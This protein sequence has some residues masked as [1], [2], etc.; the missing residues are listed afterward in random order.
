[1]NNGVV[2]LRLAFLLLLVGSSVVAGC[3]PLVPPSPSPTRAGTL[4]PSG[5]PPSGAIVHPTAPSATP[6]STPAPT[7][8]PTPSA[9]PTPPLDLVGTCYLYFPPKTKYD[10]LDYP[11]RGNLYRIDPNTGQINLLLTGDV[12]DFT[13]SPD[14]DQIAYILHGAGNNQILLRSLVDGKDKVLFEGSKRILQP[15]WSPD[16]REIA[17]IQYTNELDWWRTGEIWIVGIY[18]P[19]IRRIADGFDP[20]W[21]PD[22]QNLAYATRPREGPCEH[23]GLAV[24]D[25][26]GKRSRVVFDTDPQTWTAGQHINSDPRYGNQLLVYSPSWSPDGRYLLFS[27]SAKHDGLYRIQ[28]DSGEMLELKFARMSI[29]GQFVRG[30]ERVVALASEGQGWITLYLLAVTSVG[31]VDRRQLNQDGDVVI[32]FALSPDRRRVAFVSTDYLGWSRITFSVY[33]LQAGEEVL[34]QELFGD[35]GKPHLAARGLEWAPR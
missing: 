21:M 11:Y 19:S 27:V 16:G 28:L 10:A 5:S 17:F 4:T 35:I 12:Q 34:R 24:V 2:L 18:E 33:D 23:N 8:T 1:M 15:V 20:V 3:G 9:S 30:P 22:S 31:K 7:L 13:V 29:E 6:T 26:L 25:R 14:G 32:G